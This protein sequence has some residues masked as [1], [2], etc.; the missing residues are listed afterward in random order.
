MTQQ[1]NS[2][3]IGMIQQGR[4][5]I[6]KAIFTSSSL[7][8]LFFFL[9]ILGFYTN[10]TSVQQLFVC[11]FLSSQ[12][13]TYFALELYY[14]NKKSFWRKGMSFRLLTSIHNILISNL[15]IG[16]LLAI[17]FQQIFCLMICSLLIFGHHSIY[18]QHYF[19]NLYSI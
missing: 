6:I 17:T 10:S 9:L 13:L 19:D 5:F 8:H 16:N 11:F 12:F 18:F 7:L 1:Q 4:F 3:V 15:S 2:R 14:I